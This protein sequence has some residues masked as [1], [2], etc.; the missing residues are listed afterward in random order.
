MDKLT[1]LEK[2]TEKSLKELGDRLR[3]VRKAKGYKNYEK[4]AYDS[5]ISRS[6]YGRYEKGADMRI[7]SLLKILHAHGM[8]LSEFKRVLNVLFKGK[9]HNICSSTRIVNNMSYIFLFLIRKTIH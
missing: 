8:S 1:E 4:F 7:S 6:Q 9:R 3:A 2:F 5:D